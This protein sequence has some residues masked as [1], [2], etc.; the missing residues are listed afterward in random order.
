MDMR[1]GTATFGSV[2]MGLMSTAIVQL[3]KKYG[4]CSDVYGWEPALLPLIHKMVRKSVERSLASVGW[5]NM[6]AAAG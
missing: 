2:E 1:T 6:I 5:S 3:A 4:I